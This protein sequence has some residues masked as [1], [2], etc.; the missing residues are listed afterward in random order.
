MSTVTATEL[1]NA[2][3]ALNVAKNVIPLFNNIDNIVKQFQTVWKNN[4][5]DPSLDIYFQTYKTNIND[6][7]ASLPAINTAITDKDL[8][9]L[10]GTGN[11][12][13][14]A[15]QITNYNTY[16][17]YI[18]SSLTPYIDKSSKV[19][20]D[21]N[22]ANNAAYAKYIG[23]SNVGKYATIAAASA[24]GFTVYYPSGSAAA[25]Y[26]AAA[27]A[28]A[29]KADDD[30]A[31]AA[32]SPSPSPTSSSPGSSPSSLVKSSVSSSASSS[33]DAPTSAPTP[34]F[35]T[36]TNGILAIILCI[37]LLIIGFV[38]IRMMIPKKTT[39]SNSYIDNP[40][41]SKGGYFF[42]N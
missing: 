40:M 21:A 7:I 12:S 4:P 35:W 10:V 26:G 41:Y 20:L 8:V 3:N 30:A 28:A 13:A 36:T 31:A 9:K 15:T 16:I 39:S 27:A 32:K 33:T 17:G 11:L 14:Y 18:T 22:A 2:N 34:N 24:A 37:V 1:N 5:N 19:I 29:K 23:N 25:T 38:L 42:F 6:A